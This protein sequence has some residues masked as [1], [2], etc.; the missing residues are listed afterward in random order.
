MG[1]F[2]KRRAASLLS[3]KRRALHLKEFGM[4]DSGS[5]RFAPLSGLI[6]VLLAIVAFAVLGG[7]TPSS[8]DSQ[9]TI[10]SFYQDHYDR[11]QA[12]ALVLAISVLFLAGFVAVLV[13][14]LRDA[15]GRGKL[16]NLSMIGGTIACAGFLVAAGMHL[17][18][19]EAAHHANTLTALLALNEIDVNNFPAFAGGMAIFVIASSWSALRT[20]AAPKWIAW[21]GILLG[22]LTF[23]PAGF[24]GFLLSGLW[25][26]ALSLWLTFG[27]NASA[28]PAAAPA[29]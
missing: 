4:S 17:A 11:Q 7:D 12:A 23:T 1:W 9:Q 16:A 10:Q 8:G 5:E 29:P 25:L 27:R 15:G 14:V 21:F 22:I 2:H 13:Q 18:L 20:G 3:P 28:A 6:F 26:I 19:S 24:V